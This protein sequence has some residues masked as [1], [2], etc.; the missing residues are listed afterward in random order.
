MVV[1]VVVM[2]VVVVAGAI[3]RCAMVA[4][5]SIVC[6]CTAVLAS[7]LRVGEAMLHKC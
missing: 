4:Y 1:V 5:G 7:A 3:E 2:T 6:D